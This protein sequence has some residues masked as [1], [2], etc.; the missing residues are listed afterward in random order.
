MGNWRVKGGKDSCT[1]PF[2]VLAKEGRGIP[3]QRDASHA[4]ESRCGQPRHVL[5][6]DLLR[7]DFPTVAMCHISKQD[8]VGKSLDQC[9]RLFWAIQPANTITIASD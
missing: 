3:N 1:S 4:A 9:A 8:Q 7:E 2:G 5:I 6:D